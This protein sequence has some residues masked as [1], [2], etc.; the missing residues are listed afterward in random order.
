MPK[1]ESM[2]FPVKAISVVLVFLIHFTSLFAREETDLPSLRW[3]FSDEKS[4]YIGL[5]TVNQI[6]GRYIQNNPDINGTPQYPDYDLAIR[7]SRILLYANLLDKVFIYTQAGYDGKTYRPDKNQGFSLINLQTEYILAKE[8]LH[9]GLGLHSWNGISRYSNSL[10]SELLVVDNPGFAYPVDG[11][12]LS[13][14]QLGIYA[15]GTFSRMGYRLSV[16]KP[17]ETGNNLISSPVTTERVNENFAVKGYFTWQFLDRENSFLPYMTMNNLGRGK[18]FNLGAGFYYHPEAMLVEAKKDLSTVDP[19]LAGL[20]IMAGNYTLL[21]ELAEYSPSDIS[22]VFIASADVFLDLPG[23]RNSAFTCYIGYFFNFSGAN[24]LQSF[25]RMNISNIAAGSVLPQG[26]GS[27]EW[28]AG[29]GHIIR[30]E[31]G[32]LIHGKELNN[33]IQ[34]YGAFTWKNFDGLN[35]ASLQ[36]DAGI[37]WLINRHNIKWTLQYSSRPVYQL[38]ENEY[39]VNQNL[40]QVILQ[41]QVYF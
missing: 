15:R 20:L 17:F 18:L 19:M 10:F 3:Y 38:V 12:S 4:S 35:E 8:K 31:F 11:T 22:D 39:R 36:F 40:G 16:V 6:W 9:L 32:Y 14:S 5:H 21:Y 23:A 34:P 24:Y 13:G 25:E 27:S 33:R 1:I 29:T 28:E 2:K 7:R 37:N 41:T 26:Q 30:G